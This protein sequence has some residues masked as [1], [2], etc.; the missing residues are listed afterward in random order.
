MRPYC[1]ENGLKVC[2]TFLQFFVSYWSG[3]K[4]FF[5]HSFFPNW[6]AVRT[7][8]SQQ[9]TNFLVG[10]ATWNK[11]SNKISTVFST[12]TFYL[13]ILSL[14]PFLRGAALL[15]RRFPFWS[16]PPALFGRQMLRGSGAYGS[17][18]L[19]NKNFNLM[20][21]YEKIQQ[22]DLQSWKGCTGTGIGEYF[23]KIDEN[24]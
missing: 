18:Q 8:A 20:Y 21:K 6:S 14:L 16:E 3:G 11:V 17:V 2:Q 22:I 1:S 19:K 7:L 23:T 5:Y 24:K 15:C 12:K 13:A 4:N 9:W 10:Q